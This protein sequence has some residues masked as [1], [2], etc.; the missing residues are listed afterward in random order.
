MVIDRELER[1]VYSL[2]S[3]IDKYVNKHSVDAT[4]VYNEML[5]LVTYIILGYLCR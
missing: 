3:Y 5:N 2:Y 1:R 4:D